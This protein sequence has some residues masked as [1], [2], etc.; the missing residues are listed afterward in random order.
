LRALVKLGGS[1]ITRKEVEGSVNQEALERLCCELAEAWRRGV[2]LV[3][4]HGGGSF[5]HPVAERFGVHG[6]LRSG[7][8]HELRGFALT[9]DA[10][11]RLNR[12][13]VAQLLKAGPPAVGLQPS[14][15]MMAR[16]GVVERVFTEALESMLKLRLIPV[17][18]GDAV[19]DAE[20]GFSIAS[21][22]SIIA[23]LAPTLKPERIV[24]CVDVDGVY[25]RYP[26][27]TLIRRVWSGNIEEVRRGL[28]GARGAD[29]TGGML[30]KVESLYA[31]ARRG[32]PS[33]I[34]SGLKPGLLLKAIMGE[35]CEGT[36]IEG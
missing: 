9:N 10:A 7:S 16:R 6:G 12:L 8:L 23:S 11:A 22:E 24:L 14:A 19:M 32:Y 34:V 25:D 36:L 13:V 4:V 28:G 35:P 20:R 2:E 1:V 31:L 15:M 29:V 33:M 17:L 3:V 21:A 18:Y 26:G 5:P 30:H 27:G